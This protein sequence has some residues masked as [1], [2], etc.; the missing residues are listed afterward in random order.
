MKTGQGLVDDWQGQFGSTRFFHLLYIESM[1][2]DH[3]Q[4]NL[5]DMYSDMQPST[6]YN[7]LDYL[8]VIYRDI[9]QPT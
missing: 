7:P 3:H 8:S 1:R 5:I 4:L 6:A 2:A 9:M